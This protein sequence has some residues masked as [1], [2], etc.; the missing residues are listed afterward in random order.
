MPVVGPWFGFMIFPFAAY[1][2][3][4]YWLFPEFRIYEFELLFLSPKLMWGRVIAVAGFTVFL[5][6]FIHFIIKREKL[7]TSGLYSVVRHPQYLGI[8]VMTYGI[9]FMCF[10]YV[11]V[12]S[13]ALMV[14][15]MELFGYIMLAGYEERH[16]S[17]EYGQEYQQYK[18]KVAFIFPTPRIRK[19]PEPIFSLTI[20]LI[21]VYLLMVV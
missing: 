9:T 14:W 19:I 8:I 15:L 7:I 11:G 17:L 20:V 6:A 16:L 18:E 5:I 2:F 13:D 21:M 3:G 1:I 12:R 4:F 10:Q